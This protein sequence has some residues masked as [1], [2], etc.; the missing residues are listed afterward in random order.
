MAR[1]SAKIFNYITGYAMPERMEKL[2]YSPISMKCDLL[3]LIAVEAE[4]AQ[5]GKPS[6][7]WAKL[8]ALVDPEIIDGLYK[9]GRA[10]VRIELVIRGICCLRPGVRRGCPRTFG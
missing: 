5:A 6:G 8:N 10:G 2:S 9:A 3:R 7:I 1:D 4:N